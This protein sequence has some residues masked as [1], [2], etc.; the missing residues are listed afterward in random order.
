MKP[1]SLHAVE[2]CGILEEED[3]TLNA[4][5]LMLIGFIYN[6]SSAKTLDAICSDI[7]ENSVVHRNDRGEPAVTY[8]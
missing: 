2:E 7:I 8:K 1:S 6:T 3:N 5:I 4:I